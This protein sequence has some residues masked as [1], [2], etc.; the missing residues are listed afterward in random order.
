[1]GSWKTLLQAL[2]VGPINGGVEIDDE[3]DE[4]F[5]FAEGIKSLILS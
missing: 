4:T 1:M 5:D 2:V 3:P